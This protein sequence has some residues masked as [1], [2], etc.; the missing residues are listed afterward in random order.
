MVKKTEGIIL[1]VKIDKV[2]DEED[3]LGYI[4]SHFQE[5][6]NDFENCIDSAVTSKYVSNS[7]LSILKNCD[8]ELQEAL[9]CLNTLKNTLQLACNE[10]EESNKATLSTYNMGNLYAHTPFYK[11]TTFKIVVGVVVVA[12]VFD[13]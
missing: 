12:A 7:N 5:Y 10:Y 4:R 9:S 6:V 1:Y 13:Y 2:R 8:Y 11:T 3:S